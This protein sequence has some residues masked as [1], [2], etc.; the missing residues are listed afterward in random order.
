MKIR[1]LLALGDTPDVVCPWPSDYNLA[2]GVWCISLRSVH[3][4]LGPHFHHYHTP[5]AITCS[6]IKCK[7]TLPLGTHI[8]TPVFLNQFVV[9]ADQVDSVSE[10]Q[11][12]N[13]LT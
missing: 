12:S 8:D 1:H 2:E 11:S 5:L 7:E 3:F 6:L 4:K 9:Y 13:P 10:V